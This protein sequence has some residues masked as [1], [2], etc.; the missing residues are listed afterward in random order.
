M[1]CV[2]TRACAMRVNTSV[3]PH[4]TVDQALQ[5][6]S[7]Q[8]IQIRSN[9]DTWMSHEWIVEQHIQ[10]ILNPVLLGKCIVCQKAVSR[11]RENANINDSMS[12]HTDKSRFM[13]RLSCKYVYRN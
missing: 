3:C 6:V 7:L 1:L 9:C 8:F 12:W 13:G 5:G 2:R 11:A 10:N 4:G